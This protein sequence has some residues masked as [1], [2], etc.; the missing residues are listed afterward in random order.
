SALVNLEGL[1]ALTSIESLTIFGSP[2]TSFDGLGN[3]GTIHGLSLS[4]LPRLTTLEGLEGT[5]PSQVFLQNMPVLVE[6]GALGST[7]AIE[8]ITLLGVNALTNVDAFLGVTG[9]NLLQASQN[10]VLANLR[11]FGN[12]TAVRT[13]SIEQNP[14]LPSCEVDAIVSRIGA[15]NIDAIHTSGNTGTGTCP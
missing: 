13:L 1:E 4:N 3:V 5:K 11:G 9:V 2:L 14:N 7:G 8:N 6:L 15:E 12:V 10:A